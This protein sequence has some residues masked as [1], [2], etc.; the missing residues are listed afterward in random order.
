MQQEKATSM[1]K[2]ISQWSAASP[3]EHSKQNGWLRYGQLNH[4]QFW[5]LLHAIK[6]RK[7]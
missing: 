4:W 3:K 2:G 5:K 1:L 6:P 7:T